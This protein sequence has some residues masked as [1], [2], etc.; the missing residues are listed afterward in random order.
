MNYA[1]K[2]GAVVLACI[3]VFG[4]IGVAV[5]GER[6]PAG[7]VGVVYS[8]SGG[9]EEEALQQGWHFV[10]PTKKSTRVYSKR[11]TACSHRQGSIPCINSGQRKH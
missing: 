1:G 6:I 11:R 10:S 9:V 2:I 3:L 7:Y 8:M 5:C 4:I